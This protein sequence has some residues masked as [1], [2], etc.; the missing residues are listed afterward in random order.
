MDSDSTERAKTPREKL[1]DYSLKF[2]LAS[3]KFDEALQLQKSF[4][5]AVSKMRF[6]FHRSLSVDHKRL[7]DQ[8]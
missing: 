8:E 7:L 4:M 3:Q 6:E 2:R 1:S 5:K